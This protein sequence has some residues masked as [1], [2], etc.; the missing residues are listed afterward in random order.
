MTRVILKAMGLSDAQM[1]KAESAMLDAPN[2]YECSMDL[3]VNFTL[4][5]I[6]KLDEIAKAKKIRTDDILRL[7]L[8]AELYGKPPTTRA[9][10]EAFLDANRNK[11]PWSSLQKGLETRLNTVLEKENAHE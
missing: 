11:D 4:R 10:I 8:T 7:L 9:E 1:A 3:K 5:Q 6:H 2:A